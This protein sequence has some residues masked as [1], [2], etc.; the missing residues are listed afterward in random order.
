[1]T[2][3]RVER[4]SKWFGEGRDRHLVLDEI[5]FEVQQGET[6]AV[7]GPSGAGKTTLLRCLV[8][9]ERPSSG[10]V[11]LEGTVVDRCPE[12]IGMVFQ[13]YTRS[14][15]PWMTVV[16]NVRFP[17]RHGPNGGRLRRQSA[18]LRQR[19]GEAIEAVGL[20]A[21]AHRRP[22]QLSGGMQQR[23]SIARALASEPKLLVMDEPF[24]SVDALTRASLEDLVL[25]LRQRYEITTLLV[26]HDIDEAVYLADRIAVLSRGPARLRAT[27]DVPFG[28][29]RDQV[30]TKANPRFATLRGELFGLLV[31][32]PGRSTSVEPGE[33][34]QSGE[35]RA[36]EPGPAAEAPVRAGEGERR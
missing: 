29:G 4:L 34:R 8:G 27:L 21:A 35:R 5:S 13:D 2:L 25:S 14:L 23:V 22:W 17:L 36:E 11:L 1:M 9:L 33:T 12:G 16:D 28:D 32:H 7:V 31:E 15:F 18:L 6:I 20:T 10:S 30:Q 24:A 26:T 19:V 3:L